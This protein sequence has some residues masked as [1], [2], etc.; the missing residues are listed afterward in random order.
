M[1]TAEAW[2]AIFESWPEVIPREGIL[3][4]KFQESIP[5]ANFLISGGIL[6]LERDKPDSLGARKVMVAYDAIS[7]VKLTTPMELARF[8]VMGFQ[9][10]F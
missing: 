10:P 1:E 8:Q 7:A 3:V 5:F 6:L 4:T 9:P 2:R